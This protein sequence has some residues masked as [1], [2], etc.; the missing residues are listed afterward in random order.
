MRVSVLF[1][2][3]RDQ[4]FFYSA[5]LNRNA[6]PGY[7]TSQRSRSLRPNVDGK[8]LKEV[9]K[10]EKEKNLKILFSTVIYSK[11]KEIFA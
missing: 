4:I 1:E 6:K 9:K 3:S 8:P 7:R 5:K 10:F 11:V 2:T